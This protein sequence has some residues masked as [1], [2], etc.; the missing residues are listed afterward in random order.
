MIKFINRNILYLETKRKCYFA[1]TLRKVSTSLLIRLIAAVYLYSSS[2]IWVP[3]SKTILPESR[4]IKYLCLDSFMSFRGDNCYLYG[5][6]QWQNKYQS[7]FVC[8]SFSWGS[9]WL[10]LILKRWNI[11]QTFYWLKEHFHSELQSR[12]Y[13]TWHRLWSKFVIFH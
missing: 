4:I 3:L 8:F 10:V 6:S 1:P 12:L 7:L 2:A 13:C 11:I 5:L 9:C